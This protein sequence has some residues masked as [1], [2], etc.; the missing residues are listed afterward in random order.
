MQ[1][2]A[3]MFVDMCMNAGLDGSVGEIAGMFK[4]DAMPEGEAVGRVVEHRLS[5]CPEVLEGW[6]VNRLN[7]II[8]WAKGQNQ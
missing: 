4:P 6:E 2:T 8:E 5:R 3:T 1:L 7:E